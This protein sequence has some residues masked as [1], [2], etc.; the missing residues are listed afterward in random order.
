MNERLYW[1]HALTPLHVGSGQGLNY[2][3]LPL[4]RESLTNFPVIPGSSVKG[5]FADSHGATD[6]KREKDD[7]LARAF[8]RGGDTQATAGALSIT[9]AR[10]ACLPVRSLYG[11]FA[12]CTAPI[13][14]ERL[15]RDLRA[16]G[17]K[18]AVSGV[19]TKEAALVCPGTKLAGTGVRSMYLEDLDV[20]VQDSPQAESWATWI[21][22]QVFDKDEAWTELFK[23]RFAILPDDLFK[24]LAETATDVQ[25]HIRIDA[26]SKRVADGALWY[27]ESLPAETILAGII[28]CDTQRIGAEKS[29]QVLDLLNAKQGNPAEHFVQIGGKATV[30]KGHTRLLFPS[31]ASSN[32]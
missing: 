28:T 27:E 18:P 4:M 21:A 16:I 11:T 14:L 31:P 32:P 2:I 3:D 12:W 1:V 22:S 26:E 19:S 20:A 8:G 24:Y 10:L 30:G 5:V 23:Q 15:L 17:A 29:Q 7:T 13:I 6:E 25:P 9:D